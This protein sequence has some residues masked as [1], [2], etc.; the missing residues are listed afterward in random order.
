MRK[1]PNFLQT[2]EK[3]CGPTCLRIIAKH[4]GR[5][6]DIGLLRNLTETTREGSSLL[7]LL[8]ASRKIGFEAEGIK[9][10]YLQL[11]E[12][13]SPCIVYWNKNHY[14]VVYKI[15]SKRVYISD[16]AIGLISYKTND[17]IRRWVGD[18]ATETTQDGI[19]LIL[20]PDETSSFKFENSNFKGF[21]FLLK[22]I[23]KYR[24]FVFQLVIGLIIS[25][26]FQLI[27]PFLTQGIV[28][29]GIKQ[30]NLN[31]IYLILIGQLSLNIGSAILEIIRNYVL[32]HLGARINISLVSDFFV[33]LMNLPISYFDVKMSGDLLQ[34][35]SDH[36]RLEQI[37]T[38]TSL[39][40]I[41][42]FF[43][44]IIF[45]FILY[46]YNVSVFLVYL[47]GSITYFCWIF[48][49]LRKRKEIDYKRFNGL[50]QEQTNV[51]EMINGM[52]EIKLNNAE[53]KMMWSWEQ[54]QVRLFKISIESFTLDQT[55]SAGT[56]LINQIKNILITVLCAKLV[57][58][59]EITFGMMLSITYIVGQ[60]SA[61][62]SQMITFFRELQDAR[63]SLERL[64][65]IHD[66]PDEEI[67]KKQYITNIPTNSSI[68]FKNVSYQ[69]IGAY[70]YV[71][72][73]I[74]ITIPANQTT[75]IV[76]TSGS[77]KTTLLKLML[78]FYE[79]QEGEIFIENNSF[80]NISKKNWRNHCGVVMQEGFIFNMTIA[81]N[82]AIS[83]DE[84]D[85]I[86]LDQAIKIANI[87]DYIDSLPSR[88][89]TKIGPEG[90]G[91]S[92]GQ[93]QRI[94]LARA[95]YKNPQFLF[96]DEATSALDSKNENIIK[97]NL[98]N[99]L[100]GRT[101]VIIAHRLSTVKNADQIIVLEAG[102][103]VETG[104]HNEL[105]NNKKA[106]YSLV[107]N[108]L[109]YQNESL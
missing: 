96:L 66:K 54:V 8:E 107:K 106:Y 21:T 57:I 4:Y 59:G 46:Y 52:Q 13:F 105:L 88:Y 33:K 45:S 87:L 11:I 44:L 92:T 102:K 53:K 37:L 81:E 60:L 38:T 35:I 16:P 12:D 71:L 103:V 86:R 64:S 22:Y 108:Q 99:Y 27:L 20:E 75:A 19:V 40:T 78:G 14:V 55:Q 25:N 74:S 15:T 17:F 61:P 26:I 90:I 84:I 34:R 80:S 32:I 41:F 1:F 2:E 83:E 109:E 70:Q 68:N 36:K 69:Y 79:I 50:S 100:K 48:F 18:N 42:S 94:L 67:E 63:I 51:I 3:D 89:H 101:A 39:T 76:G 28:D 43:N 93:K 30:H 85:F 47:I 24:K 72:K 56:N 7:G 5:S 31:F 62:I 9:I 6:I 58:T 10:S 29:V 49:F 73:D 23:K 91:L 77:G 95:V 65:E 82:I 98:E 104:T 97:E